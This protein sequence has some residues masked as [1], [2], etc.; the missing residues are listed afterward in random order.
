MLLGV[1]VVA[2][3]E[4][5]STRGIAQVTALLRR[6]SECARARTGTCGGPAKLALD[7]LY[8]LDLLLTLFSPHIVGVFLE[9]ELIQNFLIDFRS[10]ELVVFVESLSQLL[11]L[12][13]LR[14]WTRFRHS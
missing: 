12:P 7:I 6:H 11:L 3:H 14:T 2:V 5:L 13:K 9:I 1:G 8:D 4:V 10:N